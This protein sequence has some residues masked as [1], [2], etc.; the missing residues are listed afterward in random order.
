MEYDEPFPYF[1][2]LVIIDASFP[3][4]FFI[5]AR[6]FSFVNTNILLV[7]NFAKNIEFEQIYNQWLFLPK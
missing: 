7:E 1:T 2:V 3:L 6:C 4:F 5:I